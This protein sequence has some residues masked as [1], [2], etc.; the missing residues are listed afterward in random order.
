MPLTRGT[1]LG[2][3]EI[4]DAIGAGGMGEVYTAT[5][6]RLHRT[7]AIKV[8]A[9]EISGDPERR[10]RFEREARVVASLS[11]P[12]ICALHDVGTV[13]SPSAGP[14]LDYLVMEYLE[15][16][17][18]ATRLSRGRLSLAE[19]VRIGVE[20]AIALDAA[21]RRQIVHRDLK[22]ANVM[23]TK[24]GVKLLDFG[25]AKAVGRSSADSDGLT[26]VVGPV[27]A[28]GTVFGT[29]PYMSPEQIEGREVD[30][31]SD[32]FALGAVLY[33][34]SVGR[35]AFSAASS[36]ALA[37]AILSADPPALTTSPGL[38]KIVRTCLNKDPDRRWQSAHDVA[39][40]LRDIGQGDAMPAAAP[41]TRRSV[42]PWVIAGASMVALLIAGWAWRASA[43]ATRGGVAEVRFTI[44]PPPGG[45]YFPI[46]V[47]RPSFAISPD[48]RDVVY[49]AG[50]GDGP[51]SVW[52]RPVSSET[53]VVIPGTERASS[54]FW[55][56]DGRS[57][58]FFVEG[59]LKRVAIDGGAA[60]KICD[61]RPGIGQAGTWG[62][63]VILFASVEGDD[64][65]RVPDTGGVPVALITHEG[66]QQNRVVWPWFLPDGRH[67]LYMAGR[68][69][70]AGAIMLG[71][72]DGPSREVL[73]GRSNAQYVAPGF[74]L[75][76]Q[77]GALLARRFDL[78]SGT[79][80]GEPIAI[81]EH[82]TQFTGTGLTQFSSSRDGV[83]LFHAGD[84]QARIVT[85]DRVGREV[86]VVRPP[87]PY[88]GLRI[89]GDGKDLL[90]D[91]TESN[92]GTY[93]VWRIELARG[94]ESRIT[95]DPGSE[96]NAVLARDGS[97]IYS[98][99]HGGPPRIYRRSAAGVDEPLA[100][101]LP[102][103]QTG[104]DLSPDGKFV[105]YSQRAARGKFDL[106][107]VSLIDRTVAGFRQTDAEEGSARF[108]PDGHWVAFV[109]DLGGRRDVYVAP[110]PGP[111]PMRIVSPSGGVLPRWSADGRELYYVA[112]DGTVFAAPIRT[113][114][115]LEIGVAQPL[116][117]RGSRARW[118]SYEP[119]RDGR[120]IAVEP[121]QYAAE[122]PIHAILGWKP[123]SR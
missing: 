47:E 92:T 84:D 3:Y 102:G 60:V 89:S 121:V 118:L 105:I 122:L 36:A 77:E 51:P 112:V 31:R 9:G 114:S 52:R 103:L 49:V 2:P 55:S 93:D 29:L 22:P 70:A 115:G 10:Q 78:A 119:T 116:F 27:T 65:L 39:L 62:D 100:P 98:A 109:S 5:D 97:M 17:T 95:S 73:P 82:A 1:R 61:V 85:F 44:P 18:L 26:T 38:E 57:I 24:S 91:Q 35:R 80:S 74:L 63:G 42:L 113:A 14:P 66:T 71:S 111:G 34:M 83:V 15:G 108:S 12:N 75:Y 56:P 99:T 68:A 48:G 30:A 37:S 110:F 53:P 33:E 76:G 81:A 87:G 13:P 11:H 45:G 117:T 25:L 88:Q 8:L 41:Q 94:T 46:N 106:M 43:G 4:L 50:V 40:Q 19:V 59:Q 90:V 86:V 101:S 16:E 28:P 120:F 6:T 7:V 69:S 20:M 54:V 123:P 107:T 58:G 64:I 21:H 96:L 79:V 67:F 72:L 104:P 23:L 32:I